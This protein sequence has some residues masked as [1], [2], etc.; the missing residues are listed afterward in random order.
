MYKYLLAILISMGAVFALASVNPN[1]TAT[2]KAVAT[3][4]A[5]LDAI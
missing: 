4:K 1:E 5:Q 3:H 2:G